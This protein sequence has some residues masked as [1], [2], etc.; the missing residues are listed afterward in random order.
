[1]S[2]SKDLSKYRDD[3]P[4]LS[5][6]MNGKPV[7][8]LDS[9]SSAQ[10]PQIVLDTINDLY[11]SSYAN[12]HRGLYSFSQSTTE[13][14]EAVREK[15]AHLIN[16]ASKDEIIFTRNTTDA[17]NLVAS[18]WGE[19]NLSEGD[20]VIIS[21]MEHHAN[22]VPWQFLEKSKG[23]TLKII[24]VLDD[25]TLDFEAFKTL[26][27]E[28]TKFLGLVYISNALGTINPIEDY[29]KAAKAHNPDII[30]LID[31]TQAVVHKPVNVQKIGCDFFTFTGHKLYGPNG[32]G[33]LW[34]KSDLIDA[35][36]P[37]Q[38]GGD[39]ID[40]VSFKS[41]TIF[42]DGP[43][44]FE[45]GTPPIAEVIALGA[46]IDYVQE[47]GLDHIAAHEEDLRQFMQSELE[48]IE[49]LK[50]YN[51]T[52]NTAAIASFTADWAHASDIAMILDQCGVAVRTGHHCCMPLMERYG[53]DATVRGSLGL[54]SNKDDIMGLV[55][56][57]K[58]AKEMLG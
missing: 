5:K 4:I 38:G 47:I 9:A 55:N 40:K 24:P 44:K 51:P 39:M 7:A 8:Y 41:G 27:S 43:A 29:M 28:R 37:Y 17:I 53:I 3:F 25:G 34:A 52:E 30:T 1:M 31:G 14:F 54:Y 33:V 49:G 19:A 11:H 12:I 42:K 15:V 2:A 35:M 45:A 23:I 18:S 16:A 10:K 50:F 32:I 26:L 56:G 13:A 46:A 20:E 36:P 6:Q 57:V 58:K 22:I 48:T 21:E